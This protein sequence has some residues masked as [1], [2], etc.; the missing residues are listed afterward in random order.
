[1][2]GRGNWHGND[3]MHSDEIELDTGSLEFHKSIKGYKEWERV[4]IDEE[5]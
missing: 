5:E 1:M 3:E 2:M 4:K